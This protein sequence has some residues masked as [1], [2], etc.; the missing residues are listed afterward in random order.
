MQ[1]NSIK[2]VKIFVK[3]HLWFIFRIL[4]YSKRY[5]LTIHVF[6]VVIKMF[7]GSNFYMQMESSLVPKSG[8][9][10]FVFRNKIVS[11]LSDSCQF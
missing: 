3:L 6:V 7:T 4:L 9:Q 1:N 11:D 8:R 10:C 5:I 2:L